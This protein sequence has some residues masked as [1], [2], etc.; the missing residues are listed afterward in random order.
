MA[1]WLQSFKRAT[2]S[3]CKGFMRMARQS[4]DWLNVLSE[5]PM[6]RHACMPAWGAS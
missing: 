1:P 4:L 6:V 2:A 5:H 3:T